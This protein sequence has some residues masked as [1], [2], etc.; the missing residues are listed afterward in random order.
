MG[1]NIF[2]QNN[3]NVRIDDTLDFFRN[4]EYLECFLKPSKSIGMY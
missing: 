1:E 4:Y 2:M 3:E